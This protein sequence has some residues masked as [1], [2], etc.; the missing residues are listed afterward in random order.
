MKIHLCYAKYRRAVFLSIIGQNLLCFFDEDMYF[1]SSEMSCHSHF[2]EA[3]GGHG[4]LTSLTH[5]SI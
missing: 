1:V 5:E 3:F 2:S 4:D